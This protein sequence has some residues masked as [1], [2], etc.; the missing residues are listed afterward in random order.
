VKKMS[1]A[2]SPA[3]NAATSRRHA[4]DGSSSTPI[5][6]QPPTQRPRLDASSSSQITQSA[7]VQSAPSASTV[8]QM[9]AK[10]A[11]LEATYDP[12][13]YTDGWPSARHVCLEDLG[14]SPLPRVV[15][16]SKGTKLK[17]VF[18]GPLHSV[19]GEVVFDGR[20]A[21]LLYEKLGL[22]KKCEKAALID[23]LN[24]LAQEFNELGV[25]THGAKVTGDGELAMMESSAIP[26]ILMKMHAD[27]FDVNIIDTAAFEG[28]LRGHKCEALCG[29]DV[30]LFSSVLQLGH[31]EDKAKVNT[32]PQY[33]IKEWSAH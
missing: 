11:Q 31:T 27:K 18:V 10:I 5:D 21:L 1:S 13:C 17:V 22:N 16:R 12:L 26:F 20:S 19:S 28:A 24:H 8:T 33:S 2:H 32:L 25:Q 7:A 23:E 15:E 3:A 6:A 9:E 4:R 29:I 30:L 14:L